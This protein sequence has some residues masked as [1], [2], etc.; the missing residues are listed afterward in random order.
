[1]TERLLKFTHLIYIYIYKSYNIR[2]RLIVHE[3]IIQLKGN[4]LQ[5][6]KM[7]LHML[8]ISVAFTLPKIYIYIKKSKMFFCYD[9]HIKA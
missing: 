7:I 8:R 1:M 6:H 5:S 4:L 9:K 3:R 2:L